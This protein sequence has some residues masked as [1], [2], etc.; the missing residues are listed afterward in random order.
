M[1]IYPGRD[2]VLRALDTW[3][4][5]PSI[6]LKQVRRGMQDYEYFWMLKDMGQGELADALVNGVVCRALMDSWVE[7][8]FTSKPWGDWSRDPADWDGAVR[9][10]A[11]AIEAGNK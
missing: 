3:E 6:R 9:R 4:V 1:L 11:E 5:I 10:A 8:E 2:P 7:G